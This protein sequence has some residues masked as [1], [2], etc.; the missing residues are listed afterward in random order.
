MG[1]ERR[2]WL[3]DA[4]YLYKGQRVF[5]DYAFDY[6]KLRD[7]LEQHGEI[8]QAYYLNAT[9]DPPTDQQ[10]AFH[11]WLKSAPPRGPKLQVDLYKLKTV[12]GTCNQCGERWERLVQQGV[13]VGIATLALTL[14]DRYDTLVLS[15][16]DGDFMKALDYIR[17]VRDKRLE[18]LV[19]TAGVSTDLQSIS[20]RI[21]WIDD[22]RDEVAKDRGSA[23]VASETDSG[24]IAPTMET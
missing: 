14:V 1:N 15:S 21:Y 13:D 22:F 8:F 19:F 5:G 10:N 17:N 2:L 3:I 23:A 4:S 18:L 16:G 12:Y 11:T 6:K 7:W 9:P 20:D 24:A